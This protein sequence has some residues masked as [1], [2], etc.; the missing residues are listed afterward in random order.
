VH[1]PLKV[2]VGRDIMHSCSPSFGSLPV[3]GL[4]F[5]QIIPVDQHARHQA[6]LWSWDLIDRIFSRTGARKAC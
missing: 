4:G 5:C 1:T 3:P 2:I 6:G